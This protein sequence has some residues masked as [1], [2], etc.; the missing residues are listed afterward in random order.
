MLNHDG[1]PSR[2]YEEIQRIGVEL[3]KLG[4]QIH[5]STLHPEAAMLLSYDSRFAFQA[6][7]NNPQL[8]N[9]NVLVDVVAP[10]LDLNR[11]KLVI[12]PAFHVVADRDVEKLRQFVET[13]GV[14]LI[15]PRS[16]VKDEANAVVNQAL[17]GA[18][19]MLCGVEVAD[20]DSL[21]PGMGNQVAWSLPGWE[22]PDT[23]TDTWSDI[24]RPTTARVIA[25]YC[26]DFYAG[27][28]AV[29]LNQVGKGQVV[30]A[31]VLGGEAF[32]DQLL[33]WLI[34]LAGIR[35]VMASPP[36]VEATERWQ[37]ENRLLF[38]LNHTDQEQALTGL[39]IESERAWTNL[40]DGAPVSPGKAA[41]GPKEVMV[42][43]PNS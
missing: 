42:L 37:G 43:Y 9:R 27:K 6:Q 26:M 7:V 35:G 3:Q 15:T 8:H 20:Y 36:G 21:M 40:L 4:E 39:A 24:L 2:R 32:Y 17:P 19:A 22:L 16:G 34:H 1:S 23:S 11:Y 29:T 38:V 30:Y 28:P 31:G 41:I 14:L 18:L 5:G 33:G 12:A 10:G 25:H 13:G